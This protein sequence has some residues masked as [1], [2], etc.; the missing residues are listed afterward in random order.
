MFR[1]L[2]D[3]DAAVVRRGTGGE[4][5]ELTIFGRDAYLFAANGIVTIRSLLLDFADSPI[6]AVQRKELCPFL[7]GSFSL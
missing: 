6:P 5:S 1:E 2:G 7:A 3:F 4:K